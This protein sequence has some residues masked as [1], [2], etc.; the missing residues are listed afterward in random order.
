MKNNIWY[1][2]ILYNNK[3]MNNY[4][5]KINKKINYNKLD[6]NNFFK[7]LYSQINYNHHNNIKN[8]IVLTMVYQLIIE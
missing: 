2:V 7:V 3:M 6:F 4:N 8:L 5:K 1:Q